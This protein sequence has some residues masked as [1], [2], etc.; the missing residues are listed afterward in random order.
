MLDGDFSCPPSTR[1]VI[2]GGS[3]LAVAHRLV[4]QQGRGGTLFVCGVR[5]ERESIA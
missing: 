3:R 2:C 5:L 1:S 4:E